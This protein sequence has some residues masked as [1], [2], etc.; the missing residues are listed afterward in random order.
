MGEA[1]ALGAAAFWA[2]SAVVIK[3]VA[4]SVL[5]AHEPF[6]MLL[7]LAGLAVLVGAR[8]VVHQPLESPA[9][10]GLGT[11]NPGFALWLSVVAA[12]LWSSSLLVVS[13]AM[14]S[15]EALTAPA[16]RLPF[17]ALALGVIAGVRGDHR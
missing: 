17:M 8:L 13:E 12:L 4:G 7:V 14:E 1:A 16:I 5:F 10:I 15:V 6:S 9:R 11:R 3:S 2:V